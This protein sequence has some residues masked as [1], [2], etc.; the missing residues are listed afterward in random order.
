MQIGYAINSHHMDHHDLDAQVSELAQVGCGRIFTDQ[1][2]RDAIMRLR[3][4]E[5]QMQKQIAELVGS[6]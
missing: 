3:G 4:S 5:Q 1:P 2:T 6:K